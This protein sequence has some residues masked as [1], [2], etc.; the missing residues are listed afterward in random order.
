MMCPAHDVEST[1]AG[2]RLPDRGS[3]RKKTRIT[4]YRGIRTIGG[5][6]I[7]VEYDSSHI[8]FDC[9]CEYDPAA[10]KQPEN[11]TDLVSLGYVP[12]LP[13][14]FDRNIHV[15]GYEWR[16][17]THEHSAVFIS[18]CHL[19]HSKMVNYIDSE[20][21]VYASEQTKAMLEAM[22]ARDDFVFPPCGSSDGGAGAVRASH[23]RS[24]NAV[25][26]GQTVKVGDIQVTLMQVDHDAYGAS[27]FRI[28]TPDAV[29][30]YTGDIRFHGFLEHATRAFMKANEGA[31]ALIIEGT[32]I[33]FRKPDEPNDWPESTERSV[34]ERIVERV[35]AEPDRQI[36][37]NYYLTNIERIR[38]LVHGVPRITVLD[39][40]A[41]S[42]YQ[43]VTGEKVH[44]YRLDDD[45]EY[46]ALDETWEVPFDELAKDH[47]R[48][49]WQ[50]D[51]T[52]HDGYLNDLD[53]DGL[54]IHTG[55][56]PLGDY[57]PAYK[58]FFQRF[59]DRGIETTTI[60]CSGHAT[61]EQAFEIIDAVRPRILFP[62]HG[63]H[64]ERYFNDYGMMILPEPGLVVEL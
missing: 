5:N 1:V 4:F 20:I 51:Q 29:I 53:A 55:A 49:F 34:C 59:A 38:H 22:D 58:P 16:A 21:P 60:S 12:Y 48:Y 10:E 46:P 30:A 56:A 7:D 63:E 9:G 25:E 64:P 13:G 44:W 35:S 41:A 17:D 39:A 57:D 54:Y 32:S 18:H 43:S 47:G 28:A 52:V 42:V 61:V 23:T 45:C 8:M 3:Q 14:V 62:V 11:L 15:P 24:I 36:T 50:L 6:L 31:D 40:Y 27:G 33:S 37:F 19:D 2:E 26:F